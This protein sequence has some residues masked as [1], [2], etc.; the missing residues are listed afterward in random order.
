MREST[1]ERDTEAR[2]ELEASGALG[3]LVRLGPER[4]RRRRKRDEGK[5]GG[6]GEHDRRS[7]QEP[8]SSF[9]GYIYPTRECECELLSRVAFSEESP[10]PTAISR[11]HR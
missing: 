8:L 1:R 5:D 3:E 6:E 4:E 2:R 10:R 11:L 7:G 9:Q